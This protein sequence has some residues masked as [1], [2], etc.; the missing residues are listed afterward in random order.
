MKNKYLDKN[1]NIL[2]LNEE[3]IDKLKNFNIDLI[4]DLWILKRNDLKKMGLATSE[5]N[6]LIIKL[7]LLG[8]D[9]NKKVYRK[10]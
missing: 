9:L 3:I 10:N 5:I 6:N 8:L 1:I 4:Q 7:Q 2:D